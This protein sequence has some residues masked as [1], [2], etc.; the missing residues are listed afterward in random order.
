MSERSWNE[1]LRETLA[2]LP[3]AGE[4]PRVSVMGIGHYLRGDDAAGLVLACLLK[5]QRFAN[6]TQIIEAGPAPI[7][8]CGLVLRH[9]PDLILFV[10]AADM[11]A[12]AGDV[13]LVEWQDVLAAGGESHQ[14]SLQVLARYLAH[15]AGCPVMLLGIQPQ[16]TGLGTTLSRSVAAA[17]QRT[18]RELADILAAEEV[19]T[20][21]SADIV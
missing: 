11:G 10:D 3:A 16:E 12:E 18:A 19:R 2:S 4:C 13:C 8:A 6:G 21:E 20:Y 7:N 5:E 9:Q 15:E 1:R 14:F 17:V